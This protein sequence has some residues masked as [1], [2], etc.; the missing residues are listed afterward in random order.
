MTLQVEV[1]QPAVQDAV[2]GFGWRVYVTNQPTDMH[3]LEQAVLSYRQEY[4]VERDF[5]R[6]KGKPISVSPMYLQSDERATGLVRL[7]SIGLRMLTLLEYHVRQRLADLQE[8]LP[9]L[10]A[11]NPKRTTD[12][13]T[14]EAILRA[15][16]GIYLSAVTIRE[17]VLY[18]VS[19]L[20][21][22][23]EKILSLLDFS[24]NIYSQLT[25]GFPK[26]AGKMT[27]P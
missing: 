17:Q 10:Y 15:F 2:R 3:S 9:S 12:R 14:A 7:L 6:L 8:K 16:K 4:L 18:H 22:V 21:D 11:G 1:D 26:P 27:E 13:P 5:A 24:T 23:Q 20:S 19:P 25:R